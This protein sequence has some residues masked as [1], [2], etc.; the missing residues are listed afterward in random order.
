MRLFYTTQAVSEYSADQSVAT[1]HV[2]YTVAIYRIKLQGILCPPPC[3][4]AYAIH[5][6]WS[7]QS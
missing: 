7:M 5:A 4:N 3:M 2:Y 6:V 1:V